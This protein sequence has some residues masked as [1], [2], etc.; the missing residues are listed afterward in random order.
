MK[1]LIQ[2]SAWMC[3]FCLITGLIGIFIYNYTYSVPV[4][5]LAVA[6][7]AAALGLLPLT[8]VTTE[9]PTPPSILGGGAYIG[10]G[11]ILNSLY[12][13]LFSGIVNII[14]TGY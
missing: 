6:L 2:N 4:G 10:L 3:R 12:F 5:W 8:C 7:M 14:T 13:Y 11:V 1:K 9:K